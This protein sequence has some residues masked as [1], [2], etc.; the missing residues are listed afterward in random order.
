TDEETIGVSCGFRS[1]T[2]GFEKLGD[3]PPQQNF[4]IQGAGPMG[5]YSTVMA[6][7]S[8]ANKVIVLDG[9]EER[10]NLA[11]KWGADYTVNIN[12]F[13]NTD[14]LTK[15]ILDLT[16]NKGPEIVIECSGHA[17]AINEGLEMIQIG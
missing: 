5:L 6:K 12:N 9:S 17:P 1:V 7:E 14:E 15:K 4:V 11:R 16:N 8:N 10:L 13:N 2:A 3:I